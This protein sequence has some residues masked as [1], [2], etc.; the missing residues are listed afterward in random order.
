VQGYNQFQ[1]DI[2]EIV[3]NEKFVSPFFHFLEDFH[4]ISPGK[5]STH[6]YGQNI[7]WCQ[8]AIIG[9]CLLNSK[10]PLMY[11]TAL[12]YSICRGE[13]S[14]FWIL[15]RGLSNRLL[16]SFVGGNKYGTTVGTIPGSLPGIV[17]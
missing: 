11:D 7:G 17:Q 14:I 6:Y 10:F 8:F 13:N 16:N 4:G 12:K 5:N 15:K 1:V 3:E 2:L 9:T